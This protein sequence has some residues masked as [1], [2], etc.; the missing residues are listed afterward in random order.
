MG[1]EV[2]R[3]GRTA[4]EVTTF[5]LGCATLGGSMHAVQDGDVRMMVIAALDAGIRYF[6]TAPL[7]GYG[8]SEHLAG[9]ALRDRSGFVIST[10]VGRRLRARRRP[11]DANDQWRKPFPF[12]PYFDYSYDGV[13]RSY[14]DSLQRLG[15]NRVDILLLHDVDTHTHGPEGQPE[16]FRR[17]MDG[18]YKALAALRGSGEVKAI[19]IG[20]NEA[21][22]IADALAH[23]DWDCFLLAGRYTLLEQAPLTELFPAVAR[24]GASVII[25]GPFNSGILVGGDTWNYTRAPEDVRNRARAMAAVC[26]AHKVP[27]P[28]AALKFPLAHPV[29][30]SVIPGPRTSDEFNQILSWWE[31]PIPASLWSDL[32]SERLIAADAP[33]PG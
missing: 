28:A 18:A 17:G 31:E 21:K 19:G 16:A 15:M 9:D 6:D 4:V 12:E 30:A 23:G 29:V 25:G 14:E 11:Q 32:K 10:K 24:H 22:P 5:G 13:M 7:Y 8:R 20:V 3:I 27:L 2:R 1:F 33:V 26:A